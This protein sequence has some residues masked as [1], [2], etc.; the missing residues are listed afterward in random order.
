MNRLQHATSPYLRQHADN[1]VDWH[2]WD[3]TAL[4][5][6]RQRDVPILLS[7]GYSA[8]HWCHVM[9]H[10]SFADPTIAELM[11][12]AFVNIKVDRE[13][14]PDL[15]RI[16]QT[17]HY[18]LTQRNGGWPLTLFLTPEDQTPFFGG[19]YFPKEARQGLPGLVDVLRRV[20][21]VYRDN[22]SAIHTQNESLRSGL[23]R[24]ERLGEPAPLSSAPLEK[25]RHSIGRSFDERHGGFSRP[26]KFPFPTLLT[27]LLRHAAAAEPLGEED[28]DAFEMA[29]LTLYRMAEGGLFDQLGG[30]FAR[31]SVDAAWMIPHFEKMLY[32]N[33]PLMALYAETYALTGDPFFRRVAEATGAWAL[34][35]MR[36]P[37]GGFASSLDAD[38]EGEEG[39]FYLWRPETAAAVL[40]PEDY[41]LL[42]RRYGLDQGPNFEG[43][44]HLHGYLSVPVLAE[45]EGLEEADLQGRLDRAR[46]RLFEARAERVPPDRDGKCLTRWNA[47]MAKGL[48]TTTRVTGEP[49]WAEAARE[50]LEFLFEALW[51]NG[52]LYAVYGDGQAYQPAYLD[53]HALLL[54]ALLEYLQVR[55]EGRYLAWAER[56]ADILLAHFEDTE[57]GGFFFTAD[58]QEALI[59]R[60]KVLSDDA[61]P[62]GNAVA[63]HGLLRLGHLLGEPRYLNAAEA[64]VKAGMETMQ[65][66]PE[67]HCRLLDVLEEWLEGSQVVILRGSGEALETWRQRSTEAYQPLR[68]TLAIPDDATDLPAALALREPHPGGPVAYLCENQQCQAPITQW[69][70]LDRELGASESRLP[71]R[72]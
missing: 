34:R 40:D 30:G 35:E 8:C 25:A 26:P 1:P 31:Y 57:A 48:A 12:A 61:L 20:A 36:L 15:D 28:P 47:L 65:R 68:L 67:A 14:R 50:T 56:L 27:R 24:L 49:R 6:A 70:T 60:P 17:A 10:E 44:W 2:P 21:A 58:D 51:R 11:N 16:Y 59:Q 32:D 42:A 39:R 64:A 3:G 4:A 37:E 29:R 52:R 7:I 69:A 33:G 23:Q 43:Q 5:E 66:V 53:D 72:G 22:R 41:R 55:W 46:A 13:E 9:A 71:N 38:S 54:E 18:L 19:T 62:S 45:L 63:A